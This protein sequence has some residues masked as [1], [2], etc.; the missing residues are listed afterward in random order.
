MNVHDYLIDQNGKD[1]AELLSG[2]LGA[3]PPS[4]TLWLVNRFGDVFVV[5]EDD[6]VHMLDVGIG[7][8]RR[9]ADNRDH[10]STEI[11]ADNN[12][13]NWLMVPLV[14]RCVA[15]GLN[16]GDNQCYGYKI[17]PMLGGEYAV[18][19]F[20]P[21]DLSV[22]YSFLAEIYQQTKDLPDGAQIR[23]VLRSPENAHV[24]NLDV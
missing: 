21:T 6:S 17:P 11:D 13:N 14:D 16:L 18:G 9:V 10:F 2:W 19:N 4:F 15:A 3:L 8:I 12:A 24:R 23:L 7:A 1:W 20:E 22:H 5:F